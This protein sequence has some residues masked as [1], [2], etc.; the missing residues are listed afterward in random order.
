MAQYFLIAAD[1]AVS[2]MFW[3]VGMGVLGFVLVGALLWGIVY[4]ILRL[5]RKIMGKDI[6]MDDTGCAE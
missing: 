5:V 6:Q 2:A 4:A 3:I 1:S